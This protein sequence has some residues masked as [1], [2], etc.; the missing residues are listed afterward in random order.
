MN[1]LQTRES[2]RTTARLI[3][4]EEACD[5]RSNSIRVVGESSVFLIVLLST[6]NF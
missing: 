4:H 2:V 1:P 3:R 6:S 5:L